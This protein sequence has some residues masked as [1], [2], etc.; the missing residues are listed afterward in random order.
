MQ[1]EATQDSAK[2]QHMASQS[3]EP[4]TRSAKKAKE[5]GKKSQVDIS[6]AAP[7]ESQADSQPILQIPSQRDPSV[8]GKIE[9]SPRK[10]KAPKE[11]K[12]KKKKRAQNEPIPEANELTSFSK[13]LPPTDEDQVV[14]LASRDDLSKVRSSI[15]NTKSAL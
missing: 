11:K 8:D 14:L 3:L 5:E 10:L 12:E 4:P 13:G 15:H 9:P 6:K 2:K 7:I 1:K